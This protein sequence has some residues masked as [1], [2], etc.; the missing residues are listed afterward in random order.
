MIYY[1]GFIHLLIF[2]VGFTPLN[3][4][5]QSAQQ[6]PLH[7]FL[8]IVVVC[9]LLDPQLCDVLLPGLHVCGLGVF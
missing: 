5:Q 9:H 8:Q 4:L 7:Q 3:E 6:Q 1:Q 2:G